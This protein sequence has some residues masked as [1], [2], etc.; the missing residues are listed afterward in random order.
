MPPHIYS[1]AQTIL[2][3]IEVALL[4]RV[5][6]SPT[7]GV[8]G[9]SDIDSQTATRLPV[10]LKRVST[11]S[12]SSVKVPT[13]AVCLLGRSGSGKSVNMEHLI[14]YLLTP[15]SRSSN[16]PSSYTHEFTLTGMFTIIL[17]FQRARHI[18]FLL[19]QYCIIGPQIF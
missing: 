14:E 8:D 19:S 12:M 15:Q 7:H 18:S 10:G 11:D 3:Q 9:S 4:A 16:S 13:Q 5:N 17:A 2:A 1:L 6:H